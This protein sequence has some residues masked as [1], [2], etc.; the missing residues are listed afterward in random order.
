MECLAIRQ[1]EGGTGDRGAS[2]G[3]APVV[4]ADGTIRPSG[5]GLRLT[6]VATACHMRAWPGLPAA[7]A[8]GRRAK[9]QASRGVAALARMIASGASGKHWAAARMEAAGK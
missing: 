7:L 5:G 3:L 6:L 1:C 9:A 8:F 2:H 4:I